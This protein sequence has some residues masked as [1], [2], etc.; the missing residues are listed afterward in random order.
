MGSHVE[1][2][3][4]SVGVRFRT[5]NKHNKLARERFEERWDTLAAAVLSFRKLVWLHPRFIVSTISSVFSFPDFSCFRFSVPPGSSESAF[6]GY[7]WRSSAAAISWFLTPGWRLE[8]FK[9]I[10]LVVHEGD[11]RSAPKLA[12]YAMELK[13]S[14]SIMSSMGEPRTQESEDN[15][16]P[17][18]IFRRR[19]GFILESERCLWHRV[20]KKEFRL[21]IKINPHTRDVVNGIRVPVYRL[22]ETK[23]PFFLFL[24]LFLFFPFL[25]LAVY[26]HL[27]IGETFDELCQSEVQSTGLKTVPISPSEKGEPSPAFLPTKSSSLTPFVFFPR[28]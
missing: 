22:M 14:C 1:S 23:F 6:F 2:Q 18:D 15:Y 24:F 7:R 25:T 28:S 13:S 9:S 4:Q 19:G 26:L 21:L 17:E 12:Y 20:I 11:I 3:A 10:D 8:A 16:P 27:G 5:G